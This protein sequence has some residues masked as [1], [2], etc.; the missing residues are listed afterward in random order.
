M[1]ALTLDQIHRPALLGTVAAKFAAFRESRRIVKLERQVAAVN[2]GRITI[3]EHLGRLGANEATIRSVE[4]KVGKAVAAAYRA[5]TGL[6]PEKTGLAIVRGQAF[7]VFA[8]P[9]TALDLVSRAALTVPAVAALI[10]A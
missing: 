9:W 5:E 3:R 7:E 4:S 6:E 10:G 1:T 2:A 8:Y